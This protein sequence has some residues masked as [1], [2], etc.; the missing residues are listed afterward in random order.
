[1]MRLDE[2]Y[3]RVAQ[4]KIVPVVAIEDAGKAVP[5]ARAL[6]AAGLSCVEVT[7]RTAA[8][9]ESMRRIAAEVPEIFLGAGTVLTPQQADT[10]AEAG[11]HFVVSPGFN[12]AVVD[13]CLDKAYPI[14][15]GCCTPSEMEQAIQRELTLVKFFPAVASGSLEYIKAVSGPY[16]MLRFM[17]TGG[18]T[19]ANLAGWLAHP[20]VVAC[21]ATWMTGGGALE[22][23]RFDEIA[24][25]CRTAVETA[26][27]AGE[28]P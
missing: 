8:G 22:A 16:P 5:L 19:Q 12:P 1:M 25:R 13:H 20:R 7:F 24:E 6:L 15:P 21:G 11:A 28:N 4:V 9:A 23:G 17:A 10:A 26:R 18:I 3:A 14:I 2:V 27:K